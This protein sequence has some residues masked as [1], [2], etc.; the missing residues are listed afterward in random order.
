MLAENLSRM[1]HWLQI[2]KKPKNIYRLSFISIDKKIKV[3]LTSK[4]CFL[5]YPSVNI[6]CEKYTARLQL[7]IKD[8]M[9]DKFQAKMQEQLTLLKQLRVHQTSILKNSCCYITVVKE[10]VFKGNSL[11][12]LKASTEKCESSPSLLYYDLSKCTI[13]MSSVNSF[14]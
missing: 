11:M 7:E 8:L 2:K 4:L 14:V 10:I 5:V 12:E 6:S 13:N 1:D 3:P 9:K